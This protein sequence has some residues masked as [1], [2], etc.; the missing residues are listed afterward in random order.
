MKK[1]VCIYLSVLVNVVATTVYA[2][3]D[4]LNSQLKTAVT[5][6]D[7]ART[8]EEWQE[9]RNLFQRINTIYP[10]DWLSGYY[11]AYTNITLF[12]RSDDADAR[13][14]LIDEA[15]AT[16]NNL[17]RIKGL[18]KEARSEIS[19]LNGYYYYALMSVDPQANGPKYSSNVIA[20]YAEALK[21][22][23]EN[24]RAILLNA[25]FQRNLSSFMGGTYATF[26]SDKAKAKELHGKEAKD[27]VLP[28]WW[29]EI[30]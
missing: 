18:S 2:Q 20:S 27:S 15:G 12:F 29:V 6:L 21:L 23:P 1:I 26:D 24:P 5:R 4:V 17:K 3:E 16:I 22:N 9:T 25:Y 11:L 7:A 28:H 10:S 8:V 30:R 14:K 19:T 13:T